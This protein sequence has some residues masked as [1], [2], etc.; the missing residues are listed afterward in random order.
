MNNKYDAAS[1]LLALFGNCDD[2]QGV[3]SLRFSPPRENVH[4]P[5]WKV[6]S[7]KKILRK[8]KERNAFFNIAT[9]FKMN[10]TKEG[11]FQIPAVWVNL[12]YSG[13]ES[14]KLMWEKIKRCKPRPSFVIKTG[15]RFQIYWLLKRPITVDNVNHYKLLRKFLFSHFEIGKVSPKASG[16]LRLPGT[17]NFKRG[18]F[19]IKLIRF[20]PH[21]RYNLDQFHSLRPKE[22]DRRGDINPTARTDEID[23]EENI[24]DNTYKVT[25]LEDIANFPDPSFI[26]ESIVP[27]E[28]LII[29]GGPPKVGKSLVALLIAKSVMDG[30]PLLG[31]QVNRTGTVLLIDEESS[32]PLLKERTQKMRFHKGLPFIVIHLEGVRVDTVEGFKRLVATVRKFKPVLIIIDCLRRVHREK[33]N[34]SASMSKVMGNLRKIVKSGLAVILIHHFRKGGNKE[35]DELDQMLRGSS[36]IA[37]AAD[38]VYALTQEDDEHVTFQTVLNRNGPLISII[39]KMEFGD[40]NIEILNEGV[41]LRGKVKILSDV[42]RLLERKGEM[43]VDELYDETGKTIGKDNFRGIL[44]HAAGKELIERR[45]PRGKKFYRID[46][47]SQ[48]RPNIYGEE[49]KKLKSSKKPDETDEDELEDL[50]NNMNF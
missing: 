14:R 8:Y 4:V 40:K 39:L 41:K 49:I 29:L 26:V 36:D 48:F 34:E 44:N 38:V 5:L 23:G 10:W 28:N 24:S 21:R 45:G 3:L 27:D 9:H 35:N 17:K 37:A 6:R 25:T 32:K 7:I 47:A 42:I 16:F 30:V 20:E 43:G 1:F 13:K 19:P 11:S 31:Y 12:K 18:Q 50:A 33:E 2:D 22:K 15:D 46:P